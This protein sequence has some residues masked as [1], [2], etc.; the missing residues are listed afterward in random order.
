[1]LRKIMNSVSVEDFSHY[2][3]NEIRNVE[4]NID[5]ILGIVITIIKGNEVARASSIFMALFYWINENIDEI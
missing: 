1:M 4:S 2:R 3:E 5:A